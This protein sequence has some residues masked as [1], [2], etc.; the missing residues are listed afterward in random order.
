MVG[1]WLFW[2]PRGSRRSAGAPKRASTWAIDMPRVG[3]AA[4][5][6]SC[7]RSISRVSAETVRAMASRA[8]NGATRAMRFMA[9]LLEGDGNAKRRCSRSPCRQAMPEDVCVTRCRKR[10]RPHRCGLCGFQAGAR[11][12]LA[13]LETGVRLADHEDLATTANH[14]AVA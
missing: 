2:P 13:S 5:F 7:T 1:H 11:L 9:R 8:R 4:L 6:S 12:A 3:R 14:L 10:K